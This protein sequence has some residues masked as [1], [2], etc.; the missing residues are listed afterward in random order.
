MPRTVSGTSTLVLLVGVLVVGSGC[1]IRVSGIVRDAKTGGPIGGA[2][3]T[4]HDG[5]NRLTVS[6][7]AGMYS[8]KTDS[9]TT[10]MTVSAPGYQPTQVAIPSGD[11]PTVYVDLKPLAHVVTYGTVVYPPPPARTDAPQAA[12]APTGTPP[13]SA[14]AP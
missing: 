5:R 2:V 7:P 12:P 3:L 10:A 11:S 4:A 6:N 13:A 8:V 14:I 1:A 9:G